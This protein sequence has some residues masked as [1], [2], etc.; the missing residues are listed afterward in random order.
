M[1]LSQ[2]ISA[3]FDGHHDDFY[4]YLNEDD[5]HWITSEL[6]RVASIS[7]GAVIS[8]LEGGYSLASTAAPIRPTA[9]SKLNINHGE[10]FELLMRFYVINVPVN[11]S[12]SPQNQ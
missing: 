3:G 4:H 6:C 5:Y 11:M 1:T 2:F 12:R 9:R 7:H 10:L 8:V